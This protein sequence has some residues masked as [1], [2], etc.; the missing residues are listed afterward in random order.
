MTMTTDSESTVNPQSSSPDCSTVVTVSTPDAV[1][2]I[3]RLGT[4]QELLGTLTVHQLI[5]RIVSP[6]SLLAVKVPVTQLEAE[7]PTAAQISE[8]LASGSGEVFIVSGNGAEERRLALDEP[9]AGIAQAQVGG[10]GSSFLSITLEVRPAGSG[11]ASTAQERRQLAMPEVMEVET[12]APAGIT[13]RRQVPISEALESRPAEA[14][15]EAE[16]L[17]PL[18][19]DSQLQP[20]AAAAQLEADPGIVAIIGKPEPKAPRAAAADDRKEYMRKSDWLRAQFLPEVQSLDFSGLF[21]GNL[22]LGIREEQTRKNVV[23]A[24]PSRITEILLRGNAYRRTNDHPKAL[25]CYQELVD[26][27]PGNADFRFLLG[28][29]LLA[30]GQH[31]EAVAALTRAKELGHDGARKELESV[32][33]PVG[34]PRSPLGFLRFWR[35]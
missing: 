14:G 29:T 24:D 20:E 27:D 23:L 8:S 6:G 26:M 19:E 32:K 33:I 2:P 11:S 3:C 30:L 13:E 7:R 16:G 18:G 15:P 12:D 25:I 35:Q 34:R 22:G 5:E 10:Q 28:R 17:V 4:S 31:S 21:V 1:T 9:A